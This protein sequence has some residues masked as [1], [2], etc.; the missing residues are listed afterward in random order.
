MFNKTA[1]L[2]GQLQ[3]VSI[4]A[5]VRGAPTCRSSSNQLCPNPLPRDGPLALTKPQRYEDCVSRNSMKTRR[6][7]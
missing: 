1:L 2:H 7:P 4:L 6:E 5:T 3:Q